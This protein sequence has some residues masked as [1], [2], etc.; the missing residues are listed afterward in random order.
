[1]GDPRAVPAL[2]KALDDKDLFVR[3]EAAE[4]LGRFQHIPGVRKKLEAKDP[5]AF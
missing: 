3:K 2:I 1:M 5:E 4:A